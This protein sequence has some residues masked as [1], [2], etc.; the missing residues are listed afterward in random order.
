MEFWNL[1]KKLIWFVEVIP[2]VLLSVGM[3]AQPAIIFYNYLQTNKSDKEVVEESTN[4]GVC[5]H[6]GQS[7][8]H[9]SGSVSDGEADGLEEVEVASNDYD[10]AAYDDARQRRGF[11]SAT[12]Q[13]GYEAGFQ[14]RSDD[15]AY[16]NPRYQQYDDTNSYDEQESQVYRLAYEKGYNVGY[17]LNYK[18]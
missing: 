12:H 13:M 7:N 1:H 11:L 16:G 3:M 17:N 18:D 4:G 2:I 8:L 6:S 9:E 10:E 5:K 14:A 15:G